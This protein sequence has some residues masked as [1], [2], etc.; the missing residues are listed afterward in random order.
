MKKGLLLAF[1][2]LAASFSASATTIT[3]TM[4]LVLGDTVYPNAQSRYGVNTPCDPGVNT[5]SGCVG[6][7]TSNITTNTTVLQNSAGT[8]SGAD[9]DNVGAYISS[10]QQLRVR[11]T[12]SGA[13]DENNNTIA[14]G[15]LVNY[16]NWAFQSLQVAIKY[17]DDANNA[18][19][20]D[21]VTEGFSV[22]AIQG[23]LAANTA[24]ESVNSVANSQIQ[25][26]A[27]SVSTV[28]YAPVSGGNLE[29]Y[30]VGNLFAEL[31]LRI[32]A[33]TGTNRDFMMRG[34]ST[35]LVVTADVDPP[36]NTV[37]EPGSM[38]L[39]GSALLGLGV[40]ARRRK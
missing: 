34:I 12:F 18:N 10:G 25:G 21:S 17:R 11:Y 28:A 3:V 14:Q 26:R 4:N 37:P 27:D 20:G 6:P 7:F 22:T 30:L 40:L 15:D 9:A 36:T 31:G 39:F 23:N 2:L 24:L 32:T 13:K 8:Q 19:N 33:N 16:S 38:A 35:Q 1:G 29:T 5:S